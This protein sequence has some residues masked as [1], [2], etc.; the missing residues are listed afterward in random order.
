MFA[1]P[2]DRSHHI[3]WS[4][5]RSKVQERLIAVQ[6]PLAA[7]ADAGGAGS[8]ELFR[9]IKNPYYL[10]DEPSLTQTL[11]WIDAWTSQP[12]AMAVAA[13]SSSD[14][15]AAVDF[16]RQSGVRLVVKGGGHSYFGNS[17]AAGSLLVWTRRMDG[18]QLHDSFRGE[19]WPSS[20]PAVPAVSVGAGAIWGRVYDKVTRSGRY[21]QGGGCLTV[22]VAGFVQGGGFG[23]LSKAFGTGAANLLEAEVVTADGRVRIVN[24]HVEPEL[25][26]ALR[27]GGGGTFGVVTRMTLKTHPLPSF[28]GASLFGIAAKSELA[29]RTLVD[30]ILSFYSDNLFNS[31]WGEQIRF[32]P[33]RKLSIA[34][35]CHG[36]DQNQ[37]EAVWRPFLSWVAERPNDY[38]LAGEPLLIAIPGSKFWDPASLRGLSGIVLQ[39]DRPDASPD[40]VFWATNLGEAGQILNAYESVWLSKDLLRPHRRQSLADALVKASNYWPVSLHTNKGLAGGSTEALTATRRTATNPEVLDAFALLICAADAKPAWPGIPGHEPDIVRGR[41]EASHVTAAMAAIRRLAPNAGCYVSEANYFDAHWKT[42]YWGENYQRLARAKRSYDP[43][44]LF[45]GH[46]T[47]EFD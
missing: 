42:A 18:M 34:M 3:D 37:V 46:H 22:G 1:K 23:S 44:N 14:I 27:G 20:A 35:V 15:A 4:L 24:E 41:Q 40:N 21:V 6:S 10:G 17:N 5:L 7:V 12:S 32:A 28:I 26:F 38:A 30:R 13:E 45:H 2:T 16:A 9:R 47:V 43:S 25:F 31:T 29:W 39:D 8:E 33:G 36:L 19:G 11:G